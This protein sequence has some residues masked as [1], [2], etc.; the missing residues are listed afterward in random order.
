[1]K[2][3]IISTKIFS[4]FILFAILLVGKAYFFYILN[5]D[6]NNLPSAINTTLNVVYVFTSILITIIFYLKLKEQKDIKKYLNTFFRGI[7]AVA[8]YFIL[9]QIVALPLVIAKVD[10]ANMPIILKSIYLLAYETV[11]LAIIYFILKDKIDSAFNDIKKNH[12]EYFS[13]YFK[14]WILALVIMSISNILISFINGGE[15]A[16][17]EE[18]VRNIFSQTPVYMFISAVFIAP[19]TEEF[20]FRQG[21]RNIFTNNKVFIITS[22]LIFGGLHV[23]GNITSWVDVLYLIPYCTPGFIFAYMLSKTDNIFVS[24]G[25]HFL[26]NGIMMSLQILLLLLGQLWS[27]FFVRNVLIY[28]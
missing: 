14:Y 16:G 13:K 12:K 5:I 8:A 21:I 1:M 11:M 22:G 9:N 2:D 4:S 7:G 20:I 27:S 28:L 10:I 19:L 26:H 23:F 6:L 15:I 3:N 25:F 18:N 24:T 17:N